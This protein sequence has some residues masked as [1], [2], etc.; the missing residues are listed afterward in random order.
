MG[1]K[2]TIDLITCRVKTHRQLVDMG[3][4]SKSQECDDAE[5]LLAIVK[6]RD[7]LLDECEKALKWYASNNHNSQ[8][9][10]GDLIT[11]IKNRNENA[12]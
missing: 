9:V 1:D 10:R 5:T 12:S 2:A 6:E 7:A 4:L 8:L 11:K 3:Q